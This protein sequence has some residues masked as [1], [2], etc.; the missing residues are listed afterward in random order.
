MPWLI[1]NHPLENC[2][3]VW[4]KTSA[5]ENF[6][7]F[8]IFGIFRVFDVFWL[9]MPL[10]VG[11]QWKFRGQVTCFY[12]WPRY[13]KLPKEFQLC[14]KNVRKGRKMSFDTPNG[15][16]ENLVKNKNFQKIGRNFCTQGA[17]GVHF[18][19]I[20]PLKASF[21]KNFENFVN[22]W[23]ILICW[24][25]SYGKNSKSYGNLKLAQMCQYPLGAL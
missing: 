18:V 20:H 7:K 1:K 3:L 14:K 21:F 24:S 6:W 10:L 12:D 5:C 15:A 16:T 17:L 19:S 4:H 22:F 13:Q 9:K 2:F 23:N 8:S 25:L 11:F